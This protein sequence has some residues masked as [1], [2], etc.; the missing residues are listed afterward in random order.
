MK[1]VIKVIEDLVKFEDLKDF[2]SAQYHTL[3]AQAKKIH[4]LQ[5]EVETLK[6]DLDRKSAEASAYSTL[7]TA[8]GSANDAETTCLVQLAV[9]KNKSM[10]GELTLE[11]TKKVEIYAKTLNLIKTKKSD[12]SDDKEAVK[13]ADTKDL[14]LLIS[15]KTQEQ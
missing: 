3:I 13:S 7:D 1:E 9:L 6:L 15:G 5:E 8:K 10:Q 4:K 11:E 12:D 14:L 2:A